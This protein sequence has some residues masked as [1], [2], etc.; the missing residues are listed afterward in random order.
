[1]AEDAKHCGACNRCVNGFDHHCRWLNNCVGSEN[2]SYF[3]KLIC[4]VFALTLFHNASDIAVLVFTH[5]NH[6]QMSKSTYFFY[7]KDMKVDYTVILTMAM[8][9]NTAALMFLGHLISF[10]LYLQSKSMT[11]FEYIQWKANKKEYKSKIFREVKHDTPIIQ[12]KHQTP[13]KEQKQEQ[14]SKI[15][16]IMNACCKRSKQQI[17]TESINDPDDKKPDSIPNN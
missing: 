8:L 9:F 13:P 14:I 6:N 15:K 5:G 16:M 1:M 4:S 2:Y 17:K 10:H 7:R 11:T 12:D 3:F